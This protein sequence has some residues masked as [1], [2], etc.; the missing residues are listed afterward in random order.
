MSIKAR[1]GFTGGVTDKQILKIVGQNVKAARLAADLTQECLA[2]MVGVH[3][4]T[5]SY[6][7]SGKFPIAITAFIR[8]TQALDTS[9]NRLLDGV[10]AGNQAQFDKI[11]KALARKRR[12]KSVSKS[13]RKK[14]L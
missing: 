9:A 13:P 2:E 4:Q 5:I 8:L 6:L 11:K 12:P 10:P 3:W 1:S 7:E 14:A